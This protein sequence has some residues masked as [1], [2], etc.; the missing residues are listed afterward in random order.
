MEGTYEEAV[1]AW[2]EV[3]FKYLQ[4][5]NEENHEKDLRYSMRFRDL[6]RLL[7]QKNQEVLPLSQ[8]DS[9]KDKVVLTDTTKK[10]YVT[11]VIQPP[12]TD[13]CRTYASKILSTSLR[14]V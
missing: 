14:G 7:L 3:L 6:D 13:R 10:C 1:V 11:H 9:S 12:S 5:G 8:F 4:G 2:C